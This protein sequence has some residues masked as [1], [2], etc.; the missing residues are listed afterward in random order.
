MSAQHLSDE[1]VAAFA[2]GVLSGHARE[3]AGR[4]AGACGECA[5][6]VRVQRE[7]VLALR[8]APAPDLPSGLLDRLRSVPATTPIR[9]F[10]AGVAPGGSAVFAAFGTIPSGKVVAPA[11]P[12]ERS[13]R[14]GPVAFTA[15]AV[16][17]A[18]VLAVASS[19]S[20]SPL[21]S[22]TRPVPGQS[23]VVPA[24]AVTGPSGDATAVVQPYSLFSYR[25]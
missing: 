2:D 13:R 17:A 25:P 1:A 10:P 15:A 20:A 18:G 6:A 22:P 23:R 5:R 3:R 11:P 24:A 19:S 21:R 9:A 8:A 16:A 4:H 12:A 7:A 14:R